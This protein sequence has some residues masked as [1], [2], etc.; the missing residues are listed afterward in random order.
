MRAACRQGGAWCTGEAASLRVSVNVSPVQLARPEFPALIAEILA[1]TELQPDRLIVEIT[2]SVLLE[3]LDEAALGIARLKALGV[4]LSVDDFGTGYS[5][6]SYLKNLPIDIVKVDREFIKDIEHSSAA[7]EIVSGIVALAHRMGLSVVAEG[8]E[9]A[10]QFYLLKSMECDH[11][12]GFLFS[13]ALPPLELEGRYLSRGT[14][15]R[16]SSFLFRR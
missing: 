10:E 13:R 16:Y 11:A 3:R 6:L 4:S 15:S 5:S 12:Q 9:T 8:V 7:R 2:E 14:G 1:M